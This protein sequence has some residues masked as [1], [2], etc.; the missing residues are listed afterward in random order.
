MKKL[1][2]FCGV[3]SLIFVLT[4]IGQRKAK[5]CTI[6]VACGKATVD[7]RPLLW[8]NDD[9]VGRENDEVVY[10]KD[11]RFKYLGVGVAY[12]ES[13]QLRAGVN[14]CGLCV[15]SSLA[16]NL[17]GKSRNYFDFIRLTLQQCVTVDDFEKL[18]KQTNVSG[19]AT[20][21]NVGVIDAFGGAA[22]FEIGNYSYTRFD[23]TDPKVAP[24]GYIVRAN[25][26]LTGR[27]GEDFGRAR[28][29]R[30]NQLFRQ[31]VENNR[32]DYRY[33]L[34]K[35]C[36]DFSG[37]EKVSYNWPEMDITEKSDFEVLNTDN[38]IGGD[39]TNAVAVFHGV[40]PDENPSFTTFWEI[41]GQ[42]LLS[43]AVPCWVIAESTAPELDGEQ[44]SPLCTIAKDLYMANYVIAKKELLL[45]PE[46][47]PDIWAVSY[48]AEDQIFDQTEKIMA[49]WRLDYPTA[50]E[51]ASFH[52]STASEAMDALEEVT[53]KLIR[54]GG[55]TASHRLALHMASVEKAKAFIEGDTN[56][57]VPDGRGYTPLHYAVR[58]NLKEIVQLLISK[59]ADINAKD[60]SGQTP[61]DIASW[62]NQNDIVGLLVANG[63]IHGSIFA[64]AYTGDLATVEACLEQ[65]A[66]IDARGK[67]L[68][69]AAEKGHKEVVELLLEH[70]VDV[71][72][73]NNN[74]QTPLDLAAS[75]GYTDIVELLI[76][77]GAD[78]NL[79]DALHYAASEGHKEIV[80]LLLENGADVNAGTDYY[81]KTAAEFAMGRGNTEIVKLLSSKGADI[82]PLH[83]AIYLKDKTKAKSL[84]E[85]GADVN[86]QTPYGTTPLN[87]AIEEGL[88]DIAR[89]LIEHGA[90]VNAGD[91]WGWTPLHSAAGD[92]YKD[93]VELLMAHGVNVNARDGDRRIPLWYAEKNGHSEIAGLLRKHGAKE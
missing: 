18:L 85:G 25:F 66:N 29:D 81:N 30:A 74:G 82:S 13:L 17:K 64:A 2:L 71:N 93:I 19:R 48:P 36:R 38:A 67:A 40:G 7:G 27:A 49:Q 50:Q 33:V 58:N 75:R 21:D 45:N 6:G 35:L 24:Q 59:H 80:E 65:G 79:K 14:E 63:A 20:Q 78:S 61:L 28:Y 3:F 86:K 8:G 4:N 5:G 54:K 52:R 60:I 57:N 47:L 90:D 44:S 16:F 1:Y 72:A 22:I 62:K 83:F 88:T 87:R 46:V 39:L 31:A 77:K 41:L 56:I 70:G 89:L 34:R 10:L 12:S 23:A 55:P 42:P 51:V 91:H 53:D 26:A 92:G 73:K 37:A 76:N 15:V 43:V 84:I 32:L 9:Q 11:G 69:L 68:Y